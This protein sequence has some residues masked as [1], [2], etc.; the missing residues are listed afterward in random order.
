LNDDS[1]VVRGWGIQLACEGGTPSDKVLAELM[2]LSRGDES[3][4]VR[5]Y[6]ASA[7]QR[8]APEKRWDILVGLVSQSADNQDHNLPLM[9]WYAAEPLADVDASRA[10]ALALEG[11]MPLIQEFMIR[12]IAAIGTPESLDLVVSAL[13]ASPDPQMQRTFLRGIRTALVGRRQ[14]PQPA[15]WPKIV[16]QLG[17]GDYPEIRTLVFSLSVKFGDPAAIARM[18]ELLANAKTRAADRKDYLAALLAIQDKELVPVL[19]ELFNEGVLRGEVIRGLAAYD[20]PQTSEF[21]LSAYGR[22]KSAEKRDVLATL[23]SRAGYARAL[24][25]AVEKKRVPAT[26]LT[27]ELVRQMR[28]LKNDEIDAQIVAV[29]GVVRDTPEE[30]AKLIAHYKQLVASHPANSDDLPLGRAVFVKTCQQ[31]HTLFGVGAKVGPELT[32]SNRADL[33]YLLSNVLDPSAVMAKEYIPLVVVTTGGRVVTGLVKEQTKSAITLVTA[34]ETV[35]IPRDE[36][37]EQKQGDKSMMPDD[38]LKPLSDVE[39]RALI[40]YLAN[41]RQTPLLATADNLAGF[42]NGKDLAGWDGNPELWRVENGEIVGT[43]KGLSRNEFL[44]NQILLGDFRLAVSVKLVPN[45]GNSGI[46]FRSE[47]LPKGEVKGYQADVGVG[48]WGKLYEEHGRALLWNE[49]GEAHVRTDDWNRYEI[50]A[51]GDRIR[52]S[53]NGKRC[54]DLD[55]PM[56]AKRGIIALQLHSGG[57]FEVRYKDFEL[58]LNPKVETAEK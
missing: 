44:V 24:L 40:A 3:P 38:L 7:L 8:M 27:A 33:A 57:P 10:L 55:D 58:E 34:N 25:G 36:I 12:R 50:I 39:A 22:L 2:S 30:K 48:W 17:E 47:A 16:K 41:P 35:I 43:S 32:G 15:G 31:C 19:H 56:G 53:I 6:I 52:T 26:D 54:V 51:V 23:A 13:A 42:F 14:V 11:N 46:Q 1:P 21:L 45:A 9:D 29:W 37:E 4:V 20:D 5:L 28:N 49:S 18:R